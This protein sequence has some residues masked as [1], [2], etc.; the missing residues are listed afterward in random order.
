MLPGR[1]PSEDKEREGILLFLFCSTGGE[2]PPSNGVCIYVVVVDGGSGGGVSLS[3]SIGEGGRGSRIAVGRW[4]GREGGEEKDLPKSGWK[5]EKKRWK[6]ARTHAKDGKKGGEKEE[7]EEEEE[8]DEALFH[9]FSRMPFSPSPLFLPISFQGLL[10]LLL[11]FRRRQTQTHLR[12]SL[13]EGETGRMDWKG[14]RRRRRC[15]RRKK[16]QK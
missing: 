11:S 8:G 2:F 16:T 9:L 14:K 1:L 6:E 10:L 5:G 3:L 15:F 12:S 7:E 13:E 4:R